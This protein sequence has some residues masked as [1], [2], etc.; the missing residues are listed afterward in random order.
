MMISV[1]DKVENIVGKGEKA[2]YYYFSFIHN[3]FE[4]LLSGSCKNQ[5]LFGKG[6]TFSTQAL[7][8]T[9]LKMK[10]FENTVGKKRKCW[11][12]AFSPFPTV[13]STIIISE[14]FNHHFGNHHFGNV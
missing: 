1:F 13:F 5:G 10:A 6:L 8:L 4:K 7:L 14:M 3:A 11:L 9:T 12:P 2:G